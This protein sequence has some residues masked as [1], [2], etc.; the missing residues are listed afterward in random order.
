MH[1]K[2]SAKR[3]SMTKSFSMASSVVSTRFPA[4]A[5]IL[6]PP[7]SPASWIS[8]DETH[9]PH[10]PETF[11][12][13]VSGFYRGRSINANIWAL[14]TSLVIGGGCSV[15]DQGK[16]SSG[17]NLT[18]QALSQYSTTLKVMY[19]DTS[20][21]LTGVLSTFM[22]IWRNGWIWRRVL[23]EGLGIHVGCDPRAGR[24][25]VILLAPGCSRIR[26]E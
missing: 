14:S 17:S 8:S 4:E 21:T 2:I 25:R 16:G 7:V 9:L 13:L 22:L 23:L 18:N 12:S 11:S 15:A 3:Y 1:C 24:P 20:T 19:W 26:S 10:L 6:E 5:G